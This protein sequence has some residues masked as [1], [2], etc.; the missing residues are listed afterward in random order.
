MHRNLLA[1]AAGLACA[2]A[3]AQTSSVTV[4]GVMDIGFTHASGDLA[5]W[6][7][8]ASNRNMG[9]R[10]GFRGSED[11]GGGLRASFVLE[12]DL[13]SDSGA[14]VT[15]PLAGWASTDNR[16]GSANG[17][18]QFNRTSMVGLAGAFGEVRFG[19]YYTPTFLV[20]AAYDPFGQNGV[21]ISLLTG[22]SVFYTPVGSVNHMRASNMILY[23]TPDLGGFT[24]MAAYAP[25]EAAAN[26]PKDGEHKSFKLGYAKGP[27]SVDV[28]AGRTTLAAV[29]DLKTTTIG[30]SYDFG[31]VR[32]MFHASEDQQGAAGANGRKR[33][34]LLGAQIPL[35]PGQVRFSW[36]RVNKTSDATTAGRVRQ[37]SVGYVHNLSKRT[38]VFATFTSIRNS[39][40]VNVGTAG[41]SVGNAVVSPNGTVR[42]QD[43]GIRHIF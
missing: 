27:L 36:A 15:T 42:A 17:S 34:V 30:A 1:A 35:G 2:S 43:F 22:T 33:G 16:S 18:L 7:G 25:S 40:Y 21:G 38:A 13:L 5:S 28:A 8:L 24:G 14:G 12:A 4:Y 41:Y 11:L 29:G 32:P 20:E 23:T 31:V 9:S 37:V 19:R 3:F 6:S 39:N 26:Q 10:L